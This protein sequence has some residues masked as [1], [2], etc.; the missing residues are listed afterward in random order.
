MELFAGL[1]V[2]EIG[3]ACA[4]YERFLGEPATFVASPDESVW[5][6]DDGRAIFV[7]HAPEHAGHA[8]VLLFV[9]DLEAQVSATAE[10]GIEPVSREEYPNGVRKANY[11]DPDGNQVGLGGVVVAD[12]GGAE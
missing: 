6:L 2:T 10:R 11:L 7:E 4:W 9:D 8:R 12:A 3:R 1:P 5:D